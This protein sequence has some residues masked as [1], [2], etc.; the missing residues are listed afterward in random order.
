M[1]ELGL[2]SSSVPDSKNEKT[3][4]FRGC[5]RTEA[6]GGLLSLGLGGASISGMTYPVP[7]LWGGITR[8][9]CVDDRDAHFDSRRTFAET[10]L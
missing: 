3:I 1:Y 9:V 10:E 4:T 7:P 8:S 5:P 6:C 2:C